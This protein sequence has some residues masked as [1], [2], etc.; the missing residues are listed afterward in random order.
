MVQRGLIDQFQINSRPDRPNIVL[1]DVQGDQRP[2]VTALMEGH[3]LPLLQVTP[4]VPARLAAL[5]GRTIEEI[6][7]T[8]GAYEYERWAL[9][10][11][12]RHTYRDTVVASESVIRGSWWQDTSDEPGWQGGSEVPRI[13]MERDV[14]EGL[15]LSVGDRVTWNVQGVEIETE[16][17]SLRQVNW[18]RFEPNFF[19]VFEPGVLDDAPQMTVILSRVD[20]PGA[21]AVFQRDLVTAFPNV[22]SLDL[23]QVQRSLDTIVDRVTLAIRFMALFSITAGLI[24]LIG[25][26]NTSRGQ[27]VRESVLLKTMG[28][29]ARQVRA[30]LVTEYFALGAMG[31]LVGVILAAAAGWAAMRFLF[32]VPFSAPVLALGGFWLGTGVLTTAVGLLA[33]RD[34]TRRP[35]LE[36]MREMSE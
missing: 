23:T 11:Q 4:I 12:Y 27:R 3:D 13:S 5:N 20:D 34:V 18:A 17:A 32:E 14:A 29:T 33:G 31:G 16:V 28:A 6:L 19:V 35:P 36:V 2:G 30:V 22:I 7:D 26:L 9:E 15:K 21:R 24:I 25:A 10:R 1:F 8:P